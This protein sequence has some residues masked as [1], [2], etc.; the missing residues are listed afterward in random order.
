M[1]KRLL[2][3]AVLLVVGVTGYTPLVKAERPDMHAKI[4][5]AMSAAP[6]AIAKDA[7]ILDYPAEVGQFFVE[8]RQGTNGWACYPD[9]PDSPGND[10]Q[11]LDE[12]WQ[13]WLEAFMNGSL[14]YVT[15]V[16]FAYKLQG[17]SDASSTTPY[18][19]EPRQGEEWV[20]TPPQVMVLVPGGL[21]TTRFS[22]EPGSDQPYI[23]WA[24]TAFEYLAIPVPDE[25]LVNLMAFPF[26][27]LN[28]PEPVTDTTTASV[29][30][31]AFPFEGLN[32][33]G[34][35]AKPAVAEAISSAGD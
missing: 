3:I 31:M 26:E 15:D 21:D 35:I 29:E 8:L 19:L 13:R 32:P 24:G 14:P 18:L 10:P 12:T 5:S 30:L 11:C 27:G 9:R 6:M 17:G 1:M 7:T 16:G 23:M 33:H 25:S 20:A 22:A 4:E 28:P 34:P 2:L